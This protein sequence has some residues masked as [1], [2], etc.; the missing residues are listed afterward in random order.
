MI[1][2]TDTSD[3]LV[4]AIGT[5]ADVPQIPKETRYSIIPSHVH[6]LNTT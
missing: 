1:T 2:L 5:V 6:Y 4:K 3:D